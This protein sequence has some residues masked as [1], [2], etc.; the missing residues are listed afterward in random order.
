ML[1]ME[2][3]KKRIIM[4]IIGVLLSGISVGIFKLAAFGVD[5]YQ[6][7]NSGLNQLIPLSYGT[8]YTALCLIMLL[9]V[10]LIDRHYIG[11]ATL[12]NLT[13]LGY[14]ADYS[15]KFFLY[16]FPDLS[17]FARLICLLI[18]VLLSCIAASLYFTAD[19]GV[20]TYDA[21]SLIA[22]HK[23]RIAKFRTCRIVSDFICVSVGIGAFLAGGGALPAI[24]SFVG[25]GTIVTAF[26]MG[27][28]IDFF[29]VHLSQPLLR[30][31]QRHPIWKIS[32]EIFT[33]PRKRRVYVKFFLYQTE[34]FLRMNPFTGRQ[35][36]RM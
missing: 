17:V 15:H 23:W 35:L 8:L 28:M 27:P 32:T 6:S 9:V 3:L 21:L 30:G 14:V 19:L 29:N 1:K 13:V 5:P 10:F 34:N 2:M 20:S 7:F 33:N 4:C 36:K 26:L 18:G 31:R 16:L 11:L 22:T 25:I 12:I 24:L